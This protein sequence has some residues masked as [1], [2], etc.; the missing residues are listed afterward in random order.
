MFRYT[1]FHSIEWQMLVET[2]WIT[3]YLMP[4]GETAKMLW[5]PHY[6]R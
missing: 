1:G 5:H 2:G 4:D 6:K 3:M